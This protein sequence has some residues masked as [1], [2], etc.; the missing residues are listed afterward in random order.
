MTPAPESSGWVL[1]LG[2]GF[3]QVPFITA[4]KSL[5][6]KVCVVDR[7]PHALGLRVA[8]AHWQYSTYDYPTIRNKLRCQTRQLETFVAVIARVS[9]P[10]LETAAK[11]SSS[12]KL[13]GINTELAKLCNSKSETRAFCRKNR[14]PAPR[15]SVCANNYYL[16][17]IQVDK[18]PWVVRPDQT[19]I[20][21]KAVTLCTSTE[22]LSTAVNEAMLCSA[23]SKVDV[24]EYKEGRDITTLMLIEGGRSHFLVG[25]EEIN[26]FSSD[27]FSKCSLRACGLEGPVSLSTSLI[28]KIE[29]FSGIISRKYF[30]VSHLIAIS[31]R[32]Q[33]DERLFLIEIHL[34]LTGD[35]ILDDLLPSAFRCDLIT[36]IT[37][38]LI[39]KTPQS[40]QVL[41]RIFNGYYEKRKIRMD[42]LG[43]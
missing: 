6:Y 13:P 3:N 33:A 41:T 38:W 5:G 36:P 17:R 26:E 25:W 42:I 4:S 19:M 40:L 21:K 34:D 16:G 27:K 43:S 9:G 8:D 1:I 24:S 32:V 22:Q 10:A 20:G 23:N 2:G 7:D 14:I 31:W 30:E 37:D 18:G 29:F 39:K 28:K 15:G 11:L 35:G 12:L